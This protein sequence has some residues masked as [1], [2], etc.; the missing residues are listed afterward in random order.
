M[1]QRQTVQRLHVHTRTSNIGRRRSHNQR[2]MRI[3]Q[4]P[5]QQANLIRAQVVTIRNSNHVNIVLA[6]SIHNVSRRSAVTKHRNRCTSNSGTRS[7]TGQIERSGGQAGSDHALQVL[8]QVLTG[9]HIRNNHDASERTTAGTRTHQTLTNQ[10]TLNEQ[11]EQTQ[12]V[13]NQQVHAGDVNLEEE[14]HNNQQTEEIGAT[15]SNETVLL[16]AETHDAQATGAVHLEDK[17]P[18]DDQ[19]D[20]QEDVINS[21]NTAIQGVNRPNVHI[22]QVSILPPETNQMRSDNRNN[23]GEKIAKVKGTLN[24]GMPAS[25]DDEV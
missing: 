23:N 16:V 21:G 1:H 24:L 9:R 12:R 4:L 20:A 14:R 5:T 10:P 19:A 2:N 8:V 13:S 25:L 11:K 22:G 17:P 3:S 15:A 6:D 18:A 7:K